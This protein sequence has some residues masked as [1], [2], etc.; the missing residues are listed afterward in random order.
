MLRVISLQALS[1]MGMSS[2]R[3]AQSLGGGVPS[4][5]GLMDGGIGR[6]TLCFRS[7]GT[8]DAQRTGREGAQLRIGCD[9]TSCFRARSYSLEYA[10]ASI[11]TNVHAACAGQP[12]LAAKTGLLEFG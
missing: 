5:V 2:V 7:A 12:I 3:N 11:G 10:A 1:F 6:P 8:P 4:D 9:D